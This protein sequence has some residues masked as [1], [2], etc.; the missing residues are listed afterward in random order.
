[1]RSVAE[2]R[3][4]LREAEEREQRTKTEC[5][6]CG[7]KGWFVD[8]TYDRSGED[9]TCGRCHGSGLPAHTVQR[10]IRDAFAPLQKPRR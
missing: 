9:V 5:M 8:S 10:I 3:N 6:G 2:I 7:G 1:M 4:E